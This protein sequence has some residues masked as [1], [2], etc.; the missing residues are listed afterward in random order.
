MWTR[1]L[2]S[3]YKGLKLDMHF[4]TAVPS[5]TGLLSAYKGLKQKRRDKYKNKGN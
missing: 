3:A 4:Q 5:E 2:L 1:S